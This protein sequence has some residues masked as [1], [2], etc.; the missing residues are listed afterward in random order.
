MTSSMHEVSEEAAALAAALHDLLGDQCTPE[1]LAVAEGSTDLALWR[2]LSE[3]GLTRIGIPEAAGGSGGGLAE[4]AVV[5]RAAGEHAAAV[6]IAESS[7]LA[8]WLLAEAGLP[9]PEL[10]ATTS[11]G[12]LQATRAGSAW[13]VSGR[14]ARV[15]SARDA[16]AVVGLATSPGGLLAV[17]LRPQDVRI[18]SGANVAGE[19]RDDVTVDVQ[20]P[21]DLVGPVSDGVA[22][23]LRLRGALS[24][25]LLTAGALDRAVALTTRYAGER[26]QFGRPVAAFQA[27]QQAVASLVGEAAAAGAAAS[28]A[29][30]LA[31]YDG[32]PGAAFPIAAAKVRSAQA[33]SAGAAVAHQ[34]H[35]ALGMTHE[36]ALR[37]TTT[38]LWS[39]RSEW[40]SEGTWS[41][42]LTAMASHAGGP[43]LWSLLVGA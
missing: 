41:E 18:M 22:D 27:V 38:R 8:G 11:D 25:A 40:G 42:R 6:P 28:G 35:G 21:A 3:S 37:F 24:R 20:L 43:G 15:P 10:L 29:T 34:V 39:W 5:L 14:L 19:P 32:V 13:R 36:H 30:A 4:A 2:L 17:S 1:R 23:E 9:Q 26:R 7:L 31:A 12:L 33:A 16:D